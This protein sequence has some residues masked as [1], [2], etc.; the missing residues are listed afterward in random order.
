[1][2]EPLSNPYSVGYAK[3]PEHSRFV[4]GKSGNPNGRPKGS[5]N[6]T[7]A[8]NRAL[9]EKITVVEHGRRKTI[10]KLDA[11]VIQMVN[12]AV[13]GDSRA[14]TQMLGLA[15][16]VGVEVVSA[17]DA[18]DQNESAVLA[19]LL[20]QFVPPPVASPPKSTRKPKPCK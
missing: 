3:P 2:K 12:R 4:K 19:T 9:R 1:M 16:L 18:I 15:P 6:L 10:T 13:Q 7:T 20:Q 11:A 8:I 17:T 14:M 5:L